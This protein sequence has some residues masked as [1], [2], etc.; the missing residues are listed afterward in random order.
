AEQQHQLFTSF[1]QLHPSLNRK[2]GG[3]GLGLAISKKLVE[4]M[5]GVIGV[6]SREHV[7]SSFY[8]TIPTHTLQDVITDK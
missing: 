5:G 1:S 6:E 7:G 4:L 2:Y 8:F 3:T